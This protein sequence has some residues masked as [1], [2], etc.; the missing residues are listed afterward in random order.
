MKKQELKEKVKMV[1]DEIEELEGKSGWFKRWKL[2]RI[3]KRRLL[4]GSSPDHIVGFHMAA[5]N[6]HKYMDE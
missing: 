4:N 6:E 2:R 1:L 3:V 5:K